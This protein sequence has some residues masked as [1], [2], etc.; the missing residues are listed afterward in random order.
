MVHTAK[1]DHHEQ[2]R[3]DRRKWAYLVKRSARYLMFG[4]TL[5]TARVRPRFLPLN[6]QKEPRERKHLAWLAAISIIL[7]GNLVA[8][9]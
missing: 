8:C 5:G 2:V 6:V 3:Y 9:A 1:G 7:L 4:V